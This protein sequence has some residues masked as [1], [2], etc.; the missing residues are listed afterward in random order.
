V[1]VVK[2]SR[3]QTRTL[4]IVFKPEALTTLRCKLQDTSATIHYLLT[5]R[6][7]NNIGNI[8]QPL[9]LVSSNPGTVSLMRS[10]EA[11][12]KW[13]LSISAD[14]R[15]LEKTID[16]VPD[17]HGFALDLDALASARLIAKKAIGVIRRKNPGAKIALIA[18]RSKLIDDSTNTWANTVGA[19]L[20]TP[21]ISAARW[22]KTGA[23]L[24]NLFSTDPDEHQ[25][26]TRRVLPHLRAA[27]RLVPADSP[28]GIIAAV[29]AQGVDLSVLATRVGRSGGV[30]ISDRSYHFKNYPECFIASEAVSWLADAAKASR[31]DAITIGRALQYCDLIYHVA[32]EQVFA[33]ENL[34]FRVARLPSA[35]MLSDFVALITSRQG[36]AIEDR[37]FL[38]AEYPRCFIGSEAMQ[39]MSAVGYNTNESMSVGQRLVSLSMAR[40]V[41]DEHP[42]K[43][44][45]LFYRLFATQL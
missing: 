42:F 11:P 2:K 4:E 16:S 32:R 30:P 33:D 27:A 44:A 7:N 20:I 12:L 19:D 35:F 17:D 40:H 1:D 29:E 24:L 9:H 22:E 34:F 38:G 43:D 41:T 31:E 3:R 36:F 14:W 23:L 28:T 15:T 5:V 45:K 10:L 8:M 37:T 39:W 13:S 6:S 26:E 18:P 25:Q 21:A